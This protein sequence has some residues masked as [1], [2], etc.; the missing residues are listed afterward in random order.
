[1]LHLLE[2]HQN[3]KTLKIN[4]NLFFNNRRT[5]Q[6]IKNPKT[7][8]TASIEGHGDSYEWGRWGSSWPK[9]EEN[10]V[11][12]HSFLGER[13]S[14]H[15]V[16]HAI[17]VLGDKSLSGL[18]SNLGIKQSKVV[19][20]EPEFLQ[21]SILTL[22]EREKLSL[23]Q[24]IPTYNHVL[25]DKFEKYMHSLSKTRKSEIPNSIIDF[26]GFGSK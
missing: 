5:D 21:L 25:R 2:K 24:T 19:L 18:L 12:Y 8:I 3:I 10:I 23:W 16:I 7:L 1:M 26:F 9:I 6:L 14:V 17:S 4:T 22:S 15:T 13:F 11:K 20:V